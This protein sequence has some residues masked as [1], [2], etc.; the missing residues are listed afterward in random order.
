MLPIS[1]SA[2]AEIL[3]AHA[4]ALVSVAGG[5][6]RGIDDELVGKTDGNPTAAACALDGG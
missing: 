3:A 2:Y 5:Q 6:G 1:P 4:T